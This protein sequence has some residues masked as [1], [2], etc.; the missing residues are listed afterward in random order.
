M[1]QAR[2]MAIDVAGV[3]AESAGVFGGV[4]HGSGLLRG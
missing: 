3:H 4:G 2:V 1:Q